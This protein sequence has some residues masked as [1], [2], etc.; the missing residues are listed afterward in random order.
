MQ[1]SQPA[2]AVSVEQ[3][4]A[5]IVRHLRSLLDH[6]PE[7]MNGNWAD[8]LLEALAMLA[9]LP[10]DSQEYSLA[11]N[12]LQNAR[13][14]VAAREPGAARFEV[15]LLLGSILRLEDNRPIRRRLRPRA[16]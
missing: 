5:N 13:R 3:S 2:I 9:T 12:R 16:N 7:N 8:G 4:Q 11:T 6:S 1:N 10:L 14:Y 15:Q